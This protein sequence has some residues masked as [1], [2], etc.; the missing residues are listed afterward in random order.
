MTAMRIAVLNDIHGNLP[1]LDAVLDEVRRADVAAVVV[2]G[3]VF[4]GPMPVLTLDRLHALPVPVHFLYGNGETEVL[5]AHRGEA[6]TRVPEPFRGTIHWSAAQLSPEG[7]AQ[8]Q[9]WPATVRLHVD[10]IGDVLFCHATPQ[11]DNAIFTE[12]TPEERLRPLFDDLGVQMVVCG[13]THM[14]F[15]RMIGSTRVI[16]AGSVGMPF[17]P[18]GADWLLLGP[19]VEFRHTDYDLTAAAERIRATPYPQATLFAEQ[20]VLHP[21]TREQALAG[22][23]KMQI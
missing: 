13:H 2:G 17:G 6:L 19:E 3:D 22:Y 23:D 20:F 15:D 12:R 9:Q 8:L 10:G 5:R 18:P 4:P 16:N 11:D 21:L 1:A 14:A 7:I